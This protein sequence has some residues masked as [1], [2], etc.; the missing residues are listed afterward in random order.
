[1]IWLFF[2]LLI[3]QVIAYPILAL[4]LIQGIINKDKPKAINSLKW[5][6]LLLIFSGLVFEKI[7]GAK[8]FWYPI[9]AVES[10][11]YTNEL[12]G[13][14]F[15][16]G[17][18]IFEWHSDRAFNGDGH[19]IEVFELSPKQIDYFQNPVSDFYTK[20]PLDKL[21]KGWITKKWRKTPLNKEDE[22]AYN[23]AVPYEISSHFNLN[24][25][26][27]ENNNFY[28]YQCKM[29]TEEIIGNI[30]FYIISPERKLIVLIN[31]NT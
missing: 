8:Y 1:M 26:I 4:K 20:F 9:E 3:F 28:A 19:S 24:E 17:E 16:L 27:N 7:P 13:K 25:I 23:F 5:L 14:S 15:I 10:K 30:D 29:H 11:F 21:R 31:H 22:T 2:L 12:T 6:F 18:P